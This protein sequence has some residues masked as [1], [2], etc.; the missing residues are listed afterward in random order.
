MVLNDDAI[1][2]NE[3][4]SVRAST[5]HRSKYSLK[6]WVAL[7]THFIVPPLTGKCIKYIFS[8]SSSFALCH[9]R[10][11]DCMVHFFLSFLDWMFPLWR[12][13]SNKEGM[14]HAMAEFEMTRAKEQKPEMVY[15]CDSLVSGGTRK[16]VWPTL[17]NC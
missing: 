13:I 9:L 8:D 14:K 7:A 1:P 6:N 11:L 16:G 3:A 10:F 17:P 12:L 4:S 2:R 5:T 15:S